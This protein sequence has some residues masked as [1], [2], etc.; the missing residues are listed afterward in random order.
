[1]QSGSYRRRAAAEQRQS[2]GA[3]LARIMQMQESV[4]LVARDVIVPPA[5]TSKQNMGK[6]WC[7]LQS[8]GFCTLNEAKADV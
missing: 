6:H 4:W 1:M 8:R 5:A 2:S 3:H 7:R